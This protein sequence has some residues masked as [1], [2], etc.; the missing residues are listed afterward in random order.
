MS[1]LEL[2]GLGHSYAQ[3]EPEALHEVSLRVEAGESVAL[4]GPNGAGKSTLLLHVAGMLGPDP[5]V[6]V[7]GVA[8]SATTL[9]EVRARVGMVFQDCDDQLFMPSVFEDVAFGPLNQGQGHDAVEAAVGAALAAVGMSDK[10]GRPPH[11]LSGGEKRRVAL[12]TVLAMRPALLLLDE[13]TSNLDARGRRQLSTILREV[14][15]ADGTALLVATHDLHFVRACCDRC[16]V[17]DEGRVVADGPMAAILD[18]SA[19]LERHGLA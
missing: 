17:L 12:A 16:V 4:L 9:K 11:H 3:G 19:L 8:L 2:D 5:R 13:P 15:A 7:G 10:A 1:L 6:R 14:V 18:D